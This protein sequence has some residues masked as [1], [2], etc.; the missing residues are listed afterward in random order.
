MLKARQLTLSQL[1]TI[2]V[3]ICLG[4]GLGYLTARGDWHFALG[5]AAL[6]PLAVL[7]S[8]YPFIGVILWL[9]LMPL[10]SALPNPELMYWAI[11]RILVP[12]SLVMTFLPH[13]FKGS[14]LPRFRIGLPEVSIALLAV[15]VP[16]SLLISGKVMSEPMR[17]YLDRILI[18]F[19]MYLT[20]RLILL[21]STELRLLQWT[22][23]FIAASQCIIGFLGLFAAHYLPYAWRPVLHGYAA[24]SLTNPNVFAGVLGFCI[25]LLFQATMDH[26][27]G[28]VKSIFIVTCG[29]SVIGIFFSMERAAWLAC[30][31][32]LL[33]LV[34]LYP[35]IMLRFLLLVAVFMVTL[36]GILFSN[37]AGK[38]ANRLNNQGTIDDRIVVTDAMLQMIQE[39]PIFGWG[40]VSLNNHIENYY[41]TVGAATA[42]IRF[43]TSHNTFLTIATELG[44]V[45]VVFYMLPLLWLLVASLRA[46]RGLPRMEPARWLRLAT[47]WLA[48]L[49]YFV[50]GNFMDMRF[51]PIGLALWWMNLGLI[52]NLLNQHAEVRE[53][54][55]S[56]QVAQKRRQAQLIDQLLLENNGTKAN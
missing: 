11:H 19:C 10:S 25:C 17:N 24:G 56:C 8:S 16:I 47:F 34:C 44:L 2:S 36:G 12:F 14:R 30:M 48:A 39:K 7:F 43:T 4:L 23:L 50:I 38:V 55:L 9:V 46:W 45:G 22:A 41:R 32:V 5:L 15:Y 13:L 3:P 29:M 37:Y 40:Y 18:P 49:Q 54:Y 52:A 21:R 26:K 20:V 1:V 33:G 28:I 42:N 6:A 35:K 27:A 53:R 31:L 51:F